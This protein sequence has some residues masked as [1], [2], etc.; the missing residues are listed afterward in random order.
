MT[1]KQKIVDGVPLEERVERFCGTF[2]MTNNEMHAY[3]L[4]FVVDKAQTAHWVFKEARR[5][6]AEPSVRARIQE[7]RDAAADALSVSVKELMQDWHDIATADPN[8]IVSHLRIA[9]RFCWGVGH[10]Y[11]WT[12]D[13]EYAE[14]CDKALRAST[15]APMP[16]MSGGFGYSEQTEPNPV[17][18]CCYG[19]GFS[20]VLIHDTTKLSPK[21]RKLYMGAKQDRFGAVEVMMHSQEKA[22]EC[23]AR[24]LGAFK[25]GIPVTPPGS[26]QQTLPENVSP[27]QAQRAYL[28]VISGRKPN[29]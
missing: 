1:T 22:R 23:L 21:A 25:D 15:I 26:G 8:E 29:A 3:R 6:L 17:C 7:L 4:A 27:E 11:Q 2:V 20:R 24:T 14:A 10:H 12:T 16:D 9:C 19:R 13:L 18:P 28:E 5:L